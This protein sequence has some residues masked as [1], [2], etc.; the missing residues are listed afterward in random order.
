MTQHI[1]GVDIATLQETLG[2][3]QKDPELGQCQFRAHNEW[4]EHSRT[5]SRI[6]TFYAEKQEME[7]LTTHEVP[8]DEPTIIGG[9]DTAANPVETLLAALAGCVTTSM[10]AHAAVQGIEIE[11]VES[12]VEGDLDLNGFAGL[13]DAPKGLQRIRLKLTVSS[14]ADP[15]QLR[16]M[17]AMSPTLNTIVDGAQVDLQVETGARA[18]TSA[19]E[20]TEQTPSMH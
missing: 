2:E 11:S 8:T 17:A 4:T 19:S 13:T 10:L 14:D 3:M 20:Y 6:R 18:G 5:V 7:H 16:Q 15:E 1:N 9:T 12:E